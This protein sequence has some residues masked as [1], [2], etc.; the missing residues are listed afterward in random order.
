MEVRGLKRKNKYKKGG[1]KVR[2][3]FVLPIFLFDQIY[4]RF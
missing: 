2:V 3:Q 4:F 1:I